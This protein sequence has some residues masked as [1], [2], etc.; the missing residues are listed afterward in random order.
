[1]FP[2][3]NYPIPANLPVETWP[4]GTGNLTLQ[5][6]QQDVNNAGGDRHA[7]IV[8]PGAGSIWETWLTKLT[9]SEWQ[10]SN[11]AKFDLNSNSLRPA[12]WTSGDA[13]RMRR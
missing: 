7:I 3:G 12:G 9:Q 5:Q 4:R 2:N 13:A 8:A 6:W 11:G 1:M 10:A